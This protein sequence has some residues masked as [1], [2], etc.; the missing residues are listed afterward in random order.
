MES[1]V[2]Q[3]A[4]LSTAAASLTASD[5]K[6]IIGK[7]RLNNRAASVTGLLL[8]DDNQFLQVLEGT[9]WAVATI[10]ERIRTDIRHNRISI[11]A[12]RTVSRREFGNWAM[13]A[14]DGEEGS[15][16]A[17]V[18]DMLRGVSCASLRAKFNN[19]ADYV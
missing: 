4:Y 12:D 5:L 8:I 15:F 13:A 3:L 19:F 11:Q 17:R 7:S 6:E 2:R 9:T 16:G 14:D 1:I 18:E 10:F